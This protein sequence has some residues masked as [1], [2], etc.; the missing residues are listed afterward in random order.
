MDFTKEN[1]HA[2]SSD[3]DEASPSLNPQVELF[4]PQVQGDPVSENDERAD[5]AGPGVSPVRPVSRP[6]RR[7]HRPEAE[8]DPPQRL[9][10]S[11]DYKY[12]FPYLREVRHYTI[13]YS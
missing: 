1:V 5:P 3:S 11:M 13:L 10:S 7:P 2:D 6:A 12:P 9:D 4:V 8:Q